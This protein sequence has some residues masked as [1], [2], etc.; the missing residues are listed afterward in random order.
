[1]KQKNFYN[2]FNLLYMAVQEDLSIYQK[3]EF[4]RRLLKD[5]YALAGDGMFDNDSIR[6]VT[7]GNIPIHVKAM[8]Y[9]HTYEGFE[10]F[11]SNIEN[12]CI[13]N[14][15]DKE[16]FISELQ[17]LCENVEFIPVEVRQ[18]LEEYLKESNYQISRAIASGLVSLNYSDYLSSRGKEKF[19][20]VGFMRLTSDKPLP[21]YPKYITDSPDAAVEELIGRKDELQ[22]LSEKICD[23]SGKLLISAVG[24]L[25]KTELVKEFLQRLKNT[26]TAVYGIE[27][28]AWVPYDNHDI[29][30][31]M[32]QAFRLQC[33]LEEVWSFVQDITADYGKR[34]L[35][36]V[37]NIEN[38]K[39]DEYMRKLGNLQ[40]RILVTSRQKSVIG[41]SEILSLQ[42]LKMQD[43][44]ELFYKHY[45]FDERDNEILNDI[46][47][48]TARLTI[49]IVF[50]A[51][52]AYLEGM[53]L[54][55]LYKKLVEK[56]FKLSEEDV[57]CEHEKMQNDETIIQQMCI[58]F[59]LVN[60]SE[61]DKT[62]LTYISVIPNL[63]FDFSKAKKWFK[64]KKNSSLMKLFQMGMLEHVTKNKAH[65]YW[66]H[67]VIAAAVREQQKGKLY[68]LS[69][70]FVDILSEELNTGPAFGREYEK[71]YLIPFSWSVADIMEEHWQDEDD[72]DF[73]TNLFHVCFACSNY[74]LC[75]KLIDVVI[76]VQKNTEKFGCMD[77]AYSYRNKIDLLLQFDRAEAA[78][79]LFDEVDELF[80]KNNI[81]EEEQQIFN[82]QYGIL[83]Q[84][85]G[86][87]EKSRS[88]FAKCIEAAENTESE[89][90]QK[91]I[92]TAYYNM[93]RM[94]VDSGDFFEAY[95]Y[96]KR[97]ISVQGE[98][99]ADAD[100]IICYSTLA[101]ICTELMNAG[102]GVHYVQ[103]ALD[104][105][106]KVIKFREKNL[107]KHHA[108]TA[109]VY[110]DYAYFL[111]V[112]EQY[113]EALKYNEMAYAIEEELFAEH[114]I[115]RMRNL[116]TKALIIW[117]QGEYEKA[118]DIFDYI[119]EISEKMSSDYLVD[120]ADFA[121]NYARCLHDQGDDEK[122]KWAYK[123]CI[124]IWS[125]MSETGNRK[126]A[127]AHQEYADCLFGEGKILEALENYEK[128][129]QNITED[130]YLQADVMDSIAACKILNGQTEEGLA[131]FEKLLRFLTEYNA[132]DSETKFQLC[133]N[134]FC[135]LDAESEEEEE[136]REKLMERIQDD[137]SVQEYVHNFLTDM[138]KK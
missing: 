14:L 124:G 33:D 117:E 128:S 107:G 138:T 77:L 27:A 65:I 55:G 83:N 132:T 15:A 60:Y 70:P 7:S 39:D 93:A 126:L 37:D 98:D 24:G 16:K 6:K 63:Q 53:S 103:E 71:A 129:E 21:Q 23:Q 74:Y 32:K 8:K 135:I 13:P 26:E 85:R 64:I 84:I 25:G 76:D 114:S 102:Y 43:C 57:S 18:Q 38:T 22:V 112:I 134:L 111:Y 48:L 92:S 50:L 118:N 61:A 12:L 91:D 130:F 34:L 58:L 116:N 82:Y 95:D 94:L 75:E 137:V 20:D 44:R 54:R 30:M 131:D 62:I 72:T 9:L 105:Y 86:N 123:K 127:M 47:D 113:E 121:F 3:E 110:H 136:L 81:P 10:S 4:Y 133:N 120:V 42:P 5:V 45:I 1:M 88:Y 28:I 56:G 49:M 99:D 31:S 19:L 101:S 122:S 46:I 104:S 79:A 51:K 40:C 115:T 41:F 17:K 69:R 106:H 67:S 59:S 100:L 108:D 90:K 36:V 11:R 73:L 68:D 87:Y 2:A 35:L 66:M 52:V 119:V 80:K 97:A 96:I 125:G 89:T 109:V 78:S 29:R